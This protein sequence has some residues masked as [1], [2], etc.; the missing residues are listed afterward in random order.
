MINVYPASSRSSADHG[1]LKSNFNFS[2]GD[3][4]DPLNTQFGP[5]RVFNDDIVQGGRGFGAHPHREMEIV[6]VVLKGQLKHEDSTGQ[7]AVTGYGEVQRMSAGTGIIHSEVNPG[8]EDVHIL[9]IWFTPN[10]SGL[11]PSYETSSFDTNAIKNALLPIV[12]HQSGERIAHIHQNLTMYMSEL[13][14]G[15]TL[16]F[17]QEQGRRIYVMVIEGELTL[18]GKTRLDRRD[19]ARI[20]QT[21]TLQI[22]TD[23]GALLLLIDLP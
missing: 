4:Y 17:V 8:T 15:H 16:Q 2:F 5:L 11:E 9:Q 3:H 12:S 20:E 13:E 22:S 6:S 14:P 19:A 10:V 21:P 7:S 1:W 18:N 23:G